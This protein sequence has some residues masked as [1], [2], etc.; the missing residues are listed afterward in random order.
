MI[1][2]GERLKRVV[3]NVTRAVIVL[4]NFYAHVHKYSIFGS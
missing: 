4:E 3:R 1:V 2:Y